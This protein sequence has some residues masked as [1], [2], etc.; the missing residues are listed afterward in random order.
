MYA[1]VLI[2]FLSKLNVRA[3]ES[4]RNV[5]G[6]FV[7]MFLDKTVNINETIIQPSQIRFLLDYGTTGSDRTY[8]ATVDPIKLINWFVGKYNELKTEDIQFCFQLG[9]QYL[10]A[11][12]VTEE[13]AVTLNN[14][15][16]SF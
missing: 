2:L 16:A 10:G 14:L 15:L 8:P 11:K 9:A 4:L 6:Y 5:V 3:T 12:N 1:S 7:Q 13:A